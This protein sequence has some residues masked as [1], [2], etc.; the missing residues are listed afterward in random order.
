MVERKGQQLGNYRLI[1]RL[2]GGR[3]AEVYL[4]EH[5]F[6]NTLAAIKI[7]QV[8]LLE[9][10]TPACLR[11]AH[12]IAGLTHPNIVRVL[13]FGVQDE[14][15]FLAME[16]ALGDTMRQNYPPG[17]R[18]S[19]A[20]VV[21]LI[22]QIANALQYAHNQNIIHGNLKPENI[23]LGQDNEVLLS[24][25]GI[26]TI[27]QTM[28]SQQVQ[29]IAYIAPEQFDGKPQRA[30]DQ[31]ALAVIAYEW[32]SGERPFQDNIAAISSQHLQALA[33]PLSGKVPGISSEVDEVLNMAMEKVPALRFS[34]IRAFAR[35]LEQAYNSTPVEAI[36]ATSEESPTWLAPISLL[37]EQETQP[38]WRS[39]EAS[40]ALVLAPSVP[41]GQSEGAPPPA[42]P[43]APSSSGH[44]PAPVPQQKTKSRAT[45]V[46]MLLI[47]CLVGVGVTGA[48][49]AV[50]PNR[51]LQIVSR[52]GITPQPTSIL[53]TSQT[54]TPITHPTPTGNTTPT[55]QPN[56]TPTTASQNPYTHSGTLAL[57][58]PL[59]DN[60]KGY[61][62]Q[63]GTNSNSATCAFQGGAYHATQPRAG[64][65]HSCTADNTDYSN[66]AFEVQMTT[67]SG[68]YAGIIFS[69]ATPDTYYLF[70]V[71][72]N[73]N[74]DLSRSVDANFDTDAVRLASGTVA[75]N[76]TN[77]IAI[78]VQHGT[79]TLYFNRELLNSVNDG[80]LTHGQIAVLAGNVNNSADIA[81]TNAKVWTL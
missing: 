54:P 5:I 39:H 36:P 73:G 11:E 49:F 18:L 23:L 61:N 41:G 10:D 71:F 66:F 47:L 25:F 14:K 56:V 19:P 13:E 57:D 44:L 1:Q 29:P 75:S 63:T 42:V 81:F 72:T 80:T 35:A 6:L 32:L 17:S 43:G 69:K 79:I 9:Q 51:V 34:S 31:Y 50:G 26:S 37:T 53:P 67:I 8:P 64:L 27:L 58:D 12:A 2:G 15:F 7:F 59:T 52:G 40:P 45:L 48:V 62:W 55:T 33:A 60:S 38:T 20:F 68:D 78:V 76:S 74:Y 3:A 70:R 21:S 30:S 16:Y 46:V 77:L 24:D 65:F 22:K 4:G 28:N